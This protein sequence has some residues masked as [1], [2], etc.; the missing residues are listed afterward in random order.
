MKRSKYLFLASIFMLGVMTGC[1]SDTPQPPD[2]PPVERVNVNLTANIASATVKVS[3][4]QWETSDKVGLYMKKAGQALGASG[5]VFA[6][7][8]NLLMSLSGNNLTS[9]PVLQYPEEGNVDFVAYYPHTTMVGADLTIPL[10]VAAQ[11][12]ALPAEP[13]FSGNVT[14]QAPVTSAVTLTFRYTLAKLVLNVTKGGG[15]E[16]P[17]FSEMTAAVDGQFT[18]AKLKLSD[19]TYTGHQ[20]KQRIKINKTTGGTAGTVTFQAL[21]LP[22]IMAA[23]EMVFVFSL[24]D[25]EYT[26]EVAGAEYEAATQYGFNFEVVIEPDPVVTLLNA[27]ITPRTTETESGVIELELE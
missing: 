16:T 6:E 20:G 7:A 21:I 9:S 14:N 25:K 15:A 17:N 22:V 1:G 3:N 27:T 5:A 2:D 11:E 18:Q 13:L 12:T 19:G 23:N 10:S 4:G 24:N 8:N 26:Y